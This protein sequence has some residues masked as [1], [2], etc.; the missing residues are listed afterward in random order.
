MAV[1]SFVPTLWSAVLLTQLQNNLVSEAFVNHNYEGIVASSGSVKIN[2]F[3]DITVANYEGTVQYQNLDVTDQTLNIDKSLYF[4][5]QLDD[6]DKAQ[7]ASSGELMTK[8][9]QRATY[10]IL[11]AKDTGMFNMMASQ[12]TVANDTINVYNAD[13]AIDALLEIKKNM[14]IANIPDVGRVIAINPD[15]EKYLL[16]NKTLA[17]TGIGDAIVKN[18]YIGELFGL[19]LYRTNN[20]YKDSDNASH[21]IATTPAFT[22]EANQ[23]EEIEALRLE[24]SFKDA[25][26]GLYVWGAKVTQP[27]GVLVQKVVF[28]KPET[29][30]E[31]E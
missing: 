4:G 5:F 21:I 23:I 6:V 14:D 29:Q 11:N 24:G 27:E 17:L 1:S 3:G 12:G 30:G 10:K 25:V 8:A 26:R 18:G 2:S 22:T 15:F 31:G 9:M 16:A 20:L 7:V 19:K 28:T 13:S